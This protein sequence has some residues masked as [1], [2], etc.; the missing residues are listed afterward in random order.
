MDLPLCGTVI[1]TQWGATSDIGPVRSSNQ[2]SWLAQD[3]LFAVADGMGGN[4][5]GELASTTALEVLSNALS[6]E[7]LDAI[8]P[9]PAELVGAIRAAAEAVASLGEKEDPAAPGTTLCGTL[10]IDQDGPQ[11]LT[12]NIGDSR[13]YLIADGSILQLTTDHSAVQEAKEFAKRTG[14]ELVL[15]PSNVITRALGAAMPELPQA[16]YVLTPMCEGDVVVLCSDGV[17]GVLS[18]QDLIDIA[19]QDASAQEIAN[20][21][22]DRAIEGGTRDNATALVIRAQSVVGSRYDGDIRASVRPR[23]PVRPLPVTTARRAR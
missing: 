9:N 11:W 16:D 2:D 4:A 12:F 20:A 10:T 21:L 6:P 19:S 13:A 1:R 5:E 17:H 8:D 23:I 14:A 7:A 15:P 3:P 18:E 22:V